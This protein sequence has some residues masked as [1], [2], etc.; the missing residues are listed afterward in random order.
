MRAM[1]LEECERL[2]GKVGISPSELQDALN[3]LHDHGLLLYYPEIEALK[4]IV[5]CDI[6][7]VFDSTSSLIMDTFTFD[8]DVPLYDKFKEK[9]QFSLQEL[10]KAA[11]DET[12]GPFTLS[13]LIELLKH[14]NV[15]TPFQRAA[16]EQSASPAAEQSL[17]QEYFMPCVLESARASDL[18]VRVSSSDPAPLMVRY[19]C[20]YMPTGVFPAMITHL[21][22]TQGGWR[23]FE[24][25]IRKNK[26]QFH[27]GQ[28]WDKVTL[29]LHTR[30]FE[31]VISQTRQSKSPSAL[32]S[33]V[34]GVIQSTLSTVTSHMN[35]HFNMSYKYGFECPAHPGKEHLCL[36]ADET[37]T[38]LE[39]PQGESIPLG[40]D[41]RKIIWFSHKEE[42]RMNR[43]NSH[44]VCS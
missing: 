21:V 10:K 34:R 18:E 8:K 11:G 43:G 7:V 12:Y 13:S 5:I 33:H 24:K 39:C 9:G 19:D 44:W 28:Y 6:Q 22:S 40:E 35:H 15:L 26:V 20:G 29:V 4:K 30:H 36:L 16:L 3:F 37:A 38:I 14:L 2:A 31:I 1:S 27:V 25:G 41:E 42:S 23:M 32:C 17:S